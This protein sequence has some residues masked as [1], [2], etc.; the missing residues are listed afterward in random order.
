MRKKDH[1]MTKQK[2]RTAA[3]TK[4][5]LKPPLHHTVKRRAKLLLVPH[6]HN[7]YQPHLVRGA[8]IA[9]VVLLVFAV[10]AFY[11]FSNSGSVLGDASSVTAE[12]LLAQTNEVRARDGA[13][14]L[15]INAALSRAATLK[16]NDMFA[17]QYWAHTSPSGV[18]PWQWFKKVGYTYNYAGENLAKN[19]TTTEGVMMAWMN[20]SEH[21]Q[22]I[23]DKDY[24]DVGFAV[25][26]GV[27]DNTQTKLVVA[28]YAAP[29]TQAAIASTAVLAAENTPGGPLS[30]LGTHLQSMSPAALGSIILL[31]LTALVAA[32]AHMY[33]KKLPR[34]L[35]QSWYRH[36]GLYKA[37]G[38]VSLAI[39]FIGL[40]GGGQ[41]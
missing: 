13:P 23:L 15:K 5:P 29:T 4:K 24:S 18:T 35:L 17:N 12:A 25:V 6:R 27:I 16:A 19:F 36:H 14:A 39:L 30:Q 20:S 40:Y 10:Q 31:L 26:P 34:P 41:I 11:N 28:L 9:V 32:T 3:K 38:M 7:Q 2:T 21:R 1:V 37:I 33:R 8:G 22:N